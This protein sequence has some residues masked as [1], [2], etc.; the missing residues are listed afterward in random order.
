MIIFVKNN[1][2]LGVFSDIQVLYN[3]DRLDSCSPYYGVRQYFFIPIINSICFKTGNGNM[4]TG[5][6]LM[7]AKPF[8]NICR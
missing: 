4:S 6:D 1:T 8:M 3:F 7:F 2:A 5:L